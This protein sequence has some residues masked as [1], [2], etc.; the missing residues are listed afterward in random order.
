MKKHLSYGVMLAIILSISLSCISFTAREDT[1][2][3]TEQRATTQGHTCN[4]HN[5]SAA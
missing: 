2:P 5:L 4:Y 3:L 1:Q